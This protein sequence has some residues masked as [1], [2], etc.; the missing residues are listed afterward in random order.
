[1]DWWFGIKSPVGRATAG[2][3]AGALGS[4]VAFYTNGTPLWLAPVCGLA[5][6]VILYFFFK[7]GSNAQGS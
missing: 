6:T 3:I 1:M 7:S 2:G 4:G 5:V